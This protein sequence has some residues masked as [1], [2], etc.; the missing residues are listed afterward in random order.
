MFLFLPAITVTLY[1]GYCR[2]NSLFFSQNCPLYP[3]GHAHR[4]ESILRVP[5]REHIL[6]QQSKRHFNIFITVIQS[7][8]I[9][10]VRNS[11]FL[12]LS[13][14]LFKGGCLPPPRQK[15]PLGRYPPGQTPPS[16]RYSPPGRHSPHA[17][18]LTETA[19]AADGTHPTGMYSCFMMVF[20]E[21]EK[22]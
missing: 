18:T 16:G 22:L 6:P 13:V 19:T 14:I 4:Q 15:P 2:S 17:D 20:N 10:T 5:P 12:R 21:I 1:I 11:S 7:R 9:I 8:N 3:S